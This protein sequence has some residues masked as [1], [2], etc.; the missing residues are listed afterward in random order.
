MRTRKAVEET[1]KRKL[2]FRV[3]RPLRD[4][5]L[6][7]AMEQ[8]ELSEDAEPALEGPVMRRPIMRS[9]I[10]RLGV[11]AAVI[12]GVVLG[13]F[14]FISTDGGSGVVW[15]E[16]A[17]KVEASWGV[18]YQQS[19]GKNESDYST[20][21]LSPTQYR[22][23]SVRAGQRW[24]TMYDDRAAGKRVVLLH[25]QKG[26]VLED[27]TATTKGDENHANAMD[28]RWW[29]RQFMAC[30]YT[31]LEAKEI[32]GTLCEGIETTDPAL[33]SDAG[34]RIDSLAARLWVSVEAGYP[35]LI[36]GEFSGEQSGIVLFEKF[37]WDVELDASV[38]E[39]NI[40][41]DYEQM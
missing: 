37:Q 26:Y 11:A 30:E 15:A 33:A 19:E 10:V 21:Y 39:P 40:P 7:R 13:L 2:R 18:V 36:E 41:A 5:L 9:P 25:T 29:V 24:M 22:S 28:P 12:T 31:Q 23:D 8:Q 14:E 38:F 1:I 4:E 32:D 27:I 16:V 20:V 34:F 35:V 3:E 6:A 17:R